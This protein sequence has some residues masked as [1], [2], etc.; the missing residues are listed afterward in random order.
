M[1]VATKKENLIRFIELLKKNGF[2]VYVPEKFTTYCHFVKDN[3]GYV[4]CSD[5]GFNFSTV[6]KPCQE[7]GTGFSVYRETWIPTIEKAN[8][9]FYIPNWVHN[10]HASIIKKYKNWKEYEETNNWTKWKPF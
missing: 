8:D 9:C 10:H 6:H 2:E 1:N 4:E 7:C 5:F 3:I